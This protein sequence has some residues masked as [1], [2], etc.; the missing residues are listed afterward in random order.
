MQL[1]QLLNKLIEMWW[2]P[3]NFYIWK[4]NIVYKDDLI[5]LS[6]TMF[7]W[8]TFSLNDL[9]SLD[10]WLW[11]FVCENWFYSW[12]TENRTYITDKNIWINVYDDRQRWFLADDRNKYEVQD[13]KY[14]LMLSSIQEDKEKLILENIK[15]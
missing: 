14:R 7:E 5:I 12:I 8:N 2:K 15:I 10:S 3:R 13:Y 1:E 4:N 6:N 9:C 11:Q